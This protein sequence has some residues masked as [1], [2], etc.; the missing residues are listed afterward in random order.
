MGFPGPVRAD[1]GRGHRQGDGKETRKRAFEPFFTTKGVGK[2]TGLGLSVS[3]YGLSNNH[4]GTVRV[5][6]SHPGPGTRSNLIPAPKR[7]PPGRAGPSTHGPGAKS[8]THRAGGGRRSA[9]APDGLAVPRGSRLPYAGGGERSER[10][11][12]D[13]A[14]RGRS[15]S[16]RDRHRDAGSQRA[17][18]G[19][20]ARARPAGAG[21]D[22]HLGIWRRRHRAGNVPERRAPGARESHSRR[23]SS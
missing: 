22:V 13:P 10:A 12:P 7:A 1:R 20:G 3:Q 2:G 16:R 23:T 4:G 21:H 19:D 18:A 5:D 15:R 6:H 9:G 11:G 17:R 8:G 14:G